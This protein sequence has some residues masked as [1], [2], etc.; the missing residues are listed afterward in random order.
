MTDAQKAEATKTTVTV[1][2]LDERYTVDVLAM[3][4]DLLEQDAAGNYGAVCREL[5]GAEQWA[6]FTAAHPSPLTV[7][8]AGELVNVALGL[9]SAIL[10]ALGNL[11]ASSGS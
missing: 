6:T 2:F 11:G 4:W 5:L 8:E 10:V 9:R 3:T 1:E 7:D